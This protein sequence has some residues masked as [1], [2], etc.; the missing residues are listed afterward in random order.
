M[1]LFSMVNNGLAT[2][3]PLTIYDFDFYHLILILCLG[4]GPAPLEN[5]LQSTWYSV[6]IAQ[7][8]SR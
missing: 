8:Y 6:W 5:N 7:C 4:A 1:R 3:E 2:E